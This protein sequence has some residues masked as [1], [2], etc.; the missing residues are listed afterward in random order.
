MK[1]VR[2]CSRCA[3]EVGGIASYSAYGGWNDTRPVR[4]AARAVGRVQPDG[5]ER[6]AVGVDDAVAFLHEERIL[7]RHAVELR[8]REPARRVGELSRRPA[9]LHHDP[10]AGRQARGLGRENRERVAARVDAFEAR[11]LV[12]GARRRA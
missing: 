2:F 1:S 10:V 6:Q 8:E 7:R 5:F 3:G 12:P 11:L 4:V 9:A